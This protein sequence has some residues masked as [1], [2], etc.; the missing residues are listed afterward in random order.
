MLTCHVY[1]E[2]TDDNK[3]E[4]GPRTSRAKM[5]FTREKI[6]RRGRVTFMCSETQE[7]GRGRGLSAKVDCVSLETETLQRLT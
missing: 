3:R 6:E 1:R 5:Y 7:K 2:G 4:R